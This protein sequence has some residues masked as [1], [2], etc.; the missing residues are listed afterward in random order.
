[1]LGAGPD[2]S[3]R[4]AVRGT[5]RMRRWEQAV[6]DESMSRVQTPGAKRP[7][8]GGGGSD[9]PR[10]GE[11]RHSTVRLRLRA[12]PLRM[13]R[14]RQAGLHCALGPGGNVGGGEPRDQKHSLASEPR[15]ESRGRKHGW[16]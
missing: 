1:M 14:G 15:V 10:G 12:G 11:A 8:G 9:L 5:L 7:R 16:G 2:H 4:K 6:T 3:S 13:R